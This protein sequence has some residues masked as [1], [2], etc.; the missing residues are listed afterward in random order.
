[1]KGLFKEPLGL[2]TQLLA[3]MLALVV[4]M[5]MFIFAWSFYLSKTTLEHELAIDTEKTE[6]IVSLSLKNTLEDIKDDLID[7]TLDAEVRSA[8]ISGDKEVLDRKL[9]EF[10]NS[11]Q[12]YLL[13]VL[14]IYRDGRNWIEAGVIELPIVQ[15]RNK[16]KNTMSSSPAWGY[17]SFRSLNNI[18]TMLVCAVPVFNKET[19]EVA[20]IL[21][22]GIDLNSNVSFIDRLKKASAAINGALISRHRLIISTSNP[23]KTEM[24]KLI[25]WTM[26]IEPGEFKIDEDLIYSTIQ[27]LPQQ[28]DSPLLFSFSR[29]NPTFK[30]LKQNYMQNLGIL[31]S[32]T[33]LLAIFTAWGLQKRILKALK[34]LT[35]YAKNVASGNRNT[36]FIPG[37]VKEFNNLGLTLEEMVSRLD[38]NSAYISKLFSSAKAPIINCDLTGTILDMNPAAAT[39]AG[40]DDNHVWSQTLTSFFHKDFHKKVTEALKQ[41]AQEDLT[42]VLELP[43]T[44][45]DGT[46]KYYIWTFSPVRMAPDSDPD[47]ILLQGLDVT[48]NR[49]AVKKAHES[50]ARLRQIIDLLPQEIFANDLEGKFLLV[51]SIKAKKMGRP[52]DEITG[53]FLPDVISDPVEVTRIMEDDLRVIERNEKLLTEKSFRDEDRNTHWI[54]TTRVPYIS[55]ENNTPAILTISTDISRIKEVEQELK[56]LNKEL[57]ERVT[58]RTTEL[59][60]ANTAL[61]K[62]MDELRQTQDKLVETEKMASLGELVAG[63][64]HEI[65]TPLGISVTSA[66]FLKELNEILH[67]SFISGQMKRSDL[68]KYLATSKEALD[69]IMKNLERSASLISN[70]K[71]LAVDQASDDIRQVNLNEYIQGI[72]LSL[73]PR[74]KQYKHKLTVDCPKGMEIYISPGSLMQV[75]TNIVSN[76]LLHAF[77]DT[78]E[79]EIS[80]TAA[81]SRNGVMLTFADN[82]IG[83]SPEQTLKVFEPFYTTARSSGNTGL[84]MHLVYNLVTRALNGTIECKS[85]PGEGT[86]YEIWFPEGK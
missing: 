77:P 58:M 54:E 18:R 74:F 27:L 42:P 78:E 13:D 83:M 49:E 82:G 17:L 1:M 52:V 50:E 67:N 72:L 3:P 43:I 39:V 30:Y 60:N 45:A 38:E 24:K 19:G 33:T 71:Q 46:V 21:Y 70:F 79:G 12:G 44:S 80:I 31:L 29:I 86:S 5:G 75:I 35:D 48:E 4:V 73:K 41:A 6:S 56:S 9:Y 8:I 36:S 26:N 68:E 62:S 40:V 23:S 59:E 20:G 85:A 63:V 69:N 81:P 61:V 65:N 66:S 2:T 53:K 57:V 25:D 84:G 28:S 10:M 64:A 22:G 32:F 34:M 15:L 51:N 76:S 11:K 7:M 55:A 37:Q 14:T 16:F 47:F